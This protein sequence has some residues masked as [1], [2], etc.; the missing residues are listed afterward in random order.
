MTSRRSLSAIYES[1]FK[2]FLR[3]GQAKRHRLLQY[4]YYSWT[5]NEIKEKTEALRFIGPRLY[6][7]SHKKHQ[8]TNKQDSLCGYVRLPNREVKFKGEKTQIEQS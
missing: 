4:T 5:R 6:K 1:P 2:Q 3:I 7:D 8:T